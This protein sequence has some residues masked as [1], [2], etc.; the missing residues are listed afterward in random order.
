MRLRWKRWL[1]FGGGYDW[2]LLRR[3]MKAAG[4]RPGVL[5]QPR[6]VAQLPAWADTLQ[7]LREQARWLANQPQ[8][9]P[10]L[11]PA[12]AMALP[13]ADLLA[14]CLLL[15]RRRLSALVAHQSP[16]GASDI[17]TSTAQAG[18]EL[19]LLQRLGKIVGPSLLALF[20]TQRQTSPLLWVLF[21]QPETLPKEHYQAFVLAQLTNG[22]QTLGE[23]WPVALRFM[24]ELVDQWAESTAEFTQRLRQ[25]HAAVCN[26]FFPGSPN[27]GD[28]VAVDATLSDPHAG[29]R[30]VLKLSFADGRRLVYKPRPM[31]MESIFSRTLDWLNA[32]WPGDH[33]RL[34]VPRV[35]VRNDYGWMEWVAEAPMAAGEESIYHWRLGSLM[36]TLRALQGCDMHQENLVAAGA[37]PVFVD[38]E[39]LL[40]P[41]ANPFLEMPIPYYADHLPKELLHMGILPFYGSADNAQGMVNLG[42]I[43][44]TAEE[45]GPQETVFRHVNSDWMHMTRDA[46]RQSTHHHPRTA[47]GWVNSFVHAEAIAT[48]YRETLGFILAQRE[49]LL[50]DEQS[51]WQDLRLARG[52][53][54]ARNT[55]NYGMLMDGAVAPEAMT[56]G[57]MFDLTFEPLHRHLHLLSSG[58]RHMAPAE[59]RDLRHLDV[60][61]FGFAADSLLLYDA[62]GRPLGNMHGATPFSA[63][64]EKLRGLRSNRVQWEADLLQLVLTEYTPPKDMSLAGL[65]TDLLRRH[66]ALDDGVALWMGLGSQGD[67]ISVH[68]MAPGLYTGTSGI[69]LALACASQML[70]STESARLAVSVLKDSLTLLPRHRTGSMPLPNPGY[71]QGMAGI[72]YAFDVCAHLTGDTHLKA[73]ARTLALDWLAVFTP[74]ENTRLGQFVDL[75]NGIAGLLLVLLRWHRAH[76]QDPEFLRAACAC[77]DHL[78]QQARTETTGIS[79]GE[80]DSPGLSGLSHGGSGFAVALTALYR[81]TGK[82]R[83]RAAAFEALAYEATLFVPEWS[84]WR[85]LR[86][87]DGGDIHQVQRCGCS[88]CHGA[89]G[90]A[91]ARAALL[92][93]LADDLAASES[94]MLERQME[95]S[96]ATTCEM[97]QHDSGPQVDD[98]CCGSA[99]SIDI[100]LECSRLLDRPALAEIARHEARKRIQAWTTPGLEQKT[101]RYWFTDGNMAGTSLSL[102]KGITGQ[103]YLQA[104]LAAPQTIPCVLLPL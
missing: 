50:T 16:A 77:G 25:D 27:P 26:T 3:R 72:L 73:E 12:G 19:A 17:L 37:H 60:P 58:Y 14:P 98:L 65:T 9:I 75:L 82:R 10:E 39:C 79:W 32:A 11:L 52:R 46:I 84:N 34:Q 90:I 23:G 36:A 54:L 24:A 59:H 62:H 51:P 96:L 89:P 35:L 66:R 31:A 42:G 102:F 47:A 18:L 68:L 21:D 6:T 30:T 103:V 38:V 76:P 5:Y 74:G 2:R 53:H 92:H 7:A 86:G 91:L 4:L 20:D 88:W 83:Y 78:L 22:Y 13:F 40:H 64:A 100:L 87:F 33:P 43:G 1:R 97:L 56:D 61:R 8:D 81:V 70:P 15:A 29:G 28:V 95:V 55:W 99:G 104:R 45:R 44:K 80:P 49:W 48:G 85:D 101:P 63:M 69:A 57:I 67:G 94:A 93:L 41:S 71:D